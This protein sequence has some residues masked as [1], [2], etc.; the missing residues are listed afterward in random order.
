[1][2]QTVI[3][4]LIYLFEHYIDDE[5]ELD[6]DRDRLKSEL[7][8]AGFESGQVAKAFDWLQDLASNRASADDQAMAASTSLRS[9]PYWA[10]MSMS[11]TAMSSGARPPEAVSSGVE[12]YQR[13]SPASDGADAPPGSEPAA[14]ATG[15]VTRISVP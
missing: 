1:M 13:S 12:P 6:A 8:S 15:S 14:P 4:I 7:H 3:D 11:G 9:G 5:I 10:R 2:K